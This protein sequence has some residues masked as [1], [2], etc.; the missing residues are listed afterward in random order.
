MKLILAFV[1]TFL[2][3]AEVFA[4]SGGTVNCKITTQTDKSASTVSTK[5]LNADS[6]RRCLVIQNQ[7]SSIVY[8]KFDSAHSSTENMQLAGGAIWQPII[9]PIN[10]IYIKTSSGVVTT[11]IL[12]GD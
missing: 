9:I 3:S 7:G 10:A 8:I 2:L 6:T 11:T 4:L 5:V 1:L 12:S